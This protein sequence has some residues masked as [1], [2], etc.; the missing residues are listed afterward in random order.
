MTPS[1]S[2]AI[3]LPTTL[4]IE[5]IFED[6][7][8]NPDHEYCLPL[9]PTQQPSQNSPQSGGSL[10]DLTHINDATITQRRDSLFAALQGLGYSSREA[11]DAV[12]VVTSTDEAPADVG[13]LLKSA[14]RAL[15]RR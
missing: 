10:E 7:T 5:T 13:A 6:R 14:L 11:D 1:L 2:N 15:D 12:A 8:V 3:E 9:S 4:V